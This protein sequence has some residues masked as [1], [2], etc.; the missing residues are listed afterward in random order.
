VV[1]DRFREYRGPNSKWFLF[2]N[3]RR[4]CWRSSTGHTTGTLNRM[5]HQS[6]CCVQELP[7]EPLVVLLDFLEVFCRGKVNIDSARL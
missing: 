3:R 5:N 7:D 2:G 1:L 4:V 6:L